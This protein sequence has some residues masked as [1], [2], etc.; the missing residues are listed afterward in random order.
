MIAR[1]L[2]GFGDVSGAG[3]GASWEVVEGERRKTEND[4]Q[5]PANS[6][7]S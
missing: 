6:R 1:I 4:R 3:F 7:I 5:N 2:Y